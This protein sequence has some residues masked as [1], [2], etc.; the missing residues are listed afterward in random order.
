MLIGHEENSHGKLY[1]NQDITTVMS[2]KIMDHFSTE[3]GEKGRVK[4]YLFTS[5]TWCLQEI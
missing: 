2:A 5:F 1:Q 4:F 3:M